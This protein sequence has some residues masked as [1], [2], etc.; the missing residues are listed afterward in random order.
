[1]AS[2]FRGMFYYSNGF[3]YAINDMP[4]DTPVYSFTNSNVIDGNFNYESTSLKDRNSVV[5]IRYIDKN[6]LYKPAARWKVT[7]I[8]KKRNPPLALHNLGFDAVLIS[9]GPNRIFYVTP[10]IFVAK[11]TLNLFTR[12]PCHDAIVMFVSS[13]YRTLR[14]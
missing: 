12:S 5:Y 8:I 13:H 10:F 6:N 3:I 7:F 2:V 11:P 9:F 1:M 14:V 4:E